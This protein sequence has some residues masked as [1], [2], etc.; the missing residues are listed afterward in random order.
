MTFSPSL[1]VQ[2]PDLTGSHGLVSEDLNGD[3][4]PD[5][6]ITSHTSGNAFV[7]R[8]TGQGNAVAFT[9]SPAYNTSTNGPVY[10][11]AGDLDGDS[12]PDLV[13]ISDT[14]SSIVFLRNTI[15]TGSVLAS[16]SNPVTGPVTNEVRVDSTVQ[17][18][19]GSPYVQRH[20]DIEPQNNAA[21]AT[22]TLTLYFTQKDFDNFN[23]YPGHGPDLPQHPTDSAGKASLRVYQYHGFSASGQPGTYSDSAVVINPA[24]DKIVWDTAALS[25]KVTFDVQGFSGFFISSVGFTYKEVAAP[26]ITVTGSAQVCQGDSVVLISSIATNNQWYKDGAAITGA[27]AKT[28]RAT[29]TGTY[30]ATALVNDV[31]TKVSLGHA[32]TVKPVPAKPVVMQSGTDL[33]SSA[34]A[35]NQWYRNGALIAG[36]TAQTYR[37]SEMG[38]YSV[39]VT[40]N[41]CMSVNSE[42]YSFSPTGVINIDGTHFISLTPNP[43][44]DFMQL[45]FNLA[46]VNNLTVQVVDMQGKTVQVFRSQLAGA[47]LPVQELITGMYLARIYNN[48]GKLSYVMKF[49]KQ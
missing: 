32:I 40:V 35:G 28:Y 49:L 21:T 1:I 36:A 12:K 45:N 5:I 7:L 48:N 19:N 20:Y 41:G 9:L 15:N 4:K 27:I 30:T 3:G 34:A 18:V 31:W 8:N 6:A 11:N 17:L 16:G 29:T 24:D 26:L 33:L 2:S 25:W 37:P 13:V 46:G 42:N 14:D 39:R 47:R 43:V 23:A 22:A 38:D 44:A 10:I